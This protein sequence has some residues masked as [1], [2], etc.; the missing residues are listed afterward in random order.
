MEIEN[1]LRQYDETLAA[2]NIKEAGAFLEK[3][4]RE[5]EE[6]RDLSAA[7][8]LYSELEG[9]WRAAC[10][11][12][13]CYSAAEKALLLL[14]AAGLTDSAAFATALLNYATA[15]TAFGE[16]QEA[17][18]VFKKLEEH[19]LRLIPA[20]DYRFACL[21]NNMAQ[22]LLRLGRARDAESY[23]E[24]SLVL[25]R[26][27]D[28]VA[29]ETAT[30]KAN[31]AVC[32]MA[33]GRLAEARAALEE[34]CAIFGEASGS[35]HYDTMLASF[36][37]LEFIEKNYDKAAEYYRRA[38]EGVEGRFG[39]NLHFAALCRNRAK[40]LSAAGK[41]FEAAQCRELAESA[42]RR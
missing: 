29:D 24:R 6:A 30:C 10:E 42:Q 15:K 20:E 12:E 36:G 37:Q 26:A 1:I 14:E 34:A 23:Y 4:A 22:C 33:D 21:Y 3:T 25:L 7:V 8:T 28:D 18:S 27:S 17:M 5:S 9:F 16:L 41:T 35:P 32:M 19:Y 31:I 40:A 2:G 38:A 13:K 39:R 11:K